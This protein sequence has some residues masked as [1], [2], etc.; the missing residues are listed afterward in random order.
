[1]CVQKNIFL[2]NFYCIVIPFFNFATGE[3]SYFMKKTHKR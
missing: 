2:K 1:M 3:D